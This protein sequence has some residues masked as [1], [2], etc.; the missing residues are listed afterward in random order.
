MEHDVKE[1]PFHVDLLICDYVFMII[2]MPTRLF[3]QDIING[4]MS[5][6]F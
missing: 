4:S 3:S 2:Q 6:D 5:H 1:D